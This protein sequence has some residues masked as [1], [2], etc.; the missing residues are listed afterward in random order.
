MVDSSDEEEDGVLMISDFE[1]DLEEDDFHINPPENQGVGEE[2]GEEGVEMGG[3][4]TSEAENSSDSEDDEENTDIDLRETRYDIGQL[5]E[6]L[7][8]NFGIKMSCQC[9]DQ[10]LLQ[11]NFCSEPFCACKNTADKPQFKANPFNKLYNSHFDSN[12]RDDDMI[13]ALSIENPVDDDLK[14]PSVCSRCFANRDTIIKATLDEFVGENGG[15]LEEALLESTE[16]KAI[17]FNLYHD[18]SG[19]DNVGLY[20]KYPTY[21]TFEQFR[22]YIAEKFD[23]VLPEAEADLAEVSTP[24][25]SPQLSSPPP[26]PSRRSRFLSRIPLRNIVSDESRETYANITQR[27]TQNSSFTQYDNEDIFVNLSDI[28]SMQERYRV[29][30]EEDAETE[31]VPLPPAIIT[32]RPSLA[33]VIYRP[34]TPPRTFTENV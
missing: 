23:L 22:E 20:R 32:T 5:L 9:C 1:N 26:L 16:V 10:A 3:E 8:G 15:E 31:S 30:I 17:F 12:R 4:T 11:C 33:S 25:H 27:H 7:G 14:A 28:I 19:Q 6:T 34:P 2:G 13:R 18:T 21:E 29:A 24:E